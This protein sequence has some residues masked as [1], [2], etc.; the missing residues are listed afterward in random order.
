MLIKFVRIKNL[1]AVKNETVQLDPYTCFVG[2]N[3]VGKSTVLCALNIFFRET[4]NSSTNLS[5]LDAEDFHLRNTDV[6]IEIT[7]TFGNLSPDETETFKDYVRQDVLIVT[8]KAVFDP[9]AGHAVVRQFGSRMAMPQFA[10]Y[11]ERAKGGAKAQELKEIFAK[12]SADFPDMEKLGASME[13]M[14]ASLN[15]YEAGKPELCQPLPSEDQFYGVGQVGK[16]RPYVQ[17]IY[18]PAVKDAADEQ[19]EAGNTALGR[20]LARTVRAKV[21]FSEKLQAIRA[22]AEKQYKALMEAEQGILDD[23]SKALQERLAE[24]SNPD[25][26]A[27]LSWQQDPKKTVS[28]PEPMAKLTAGDGQFEG[29]IARFGHGMQ[30]SY[31]IALLQGLASLDDANQPLLVLGCEEPELYQHPPQARHLSAVLQKL[32]ESNTQVILTTHSPLFVDGGGFESV[33]LV[34][35]NPVTGEAKVRQMTLQQLSE[36][37]AAAAKE[38]PKQINATLVK[39]HQALQP[40]LSEMFFTSKLI[41]VEG[42]EDEAYITAWLRLTN[43]WDDFRRG[44]CH[45]VPCSGKSEIA[46]PL[47]IAL[48]LSV[49]VFAI[50]DADGDKLSHSDPN[51]ANSRRTLHEKDNLKILRLVGGPEDAFPMATVWGQRFVVWPKDMAATVKEEVGAVQWDKLGTA[52][53]RSFDNEADLQKNTLHIAERLFTA[54]EAKIAVPTLDKLCEAIL[55]FG[56]VPTR[57]ENAPPMANQDAP[58]TMEK[59]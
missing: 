35:K 42:L 5:H 34:Q 52:A 24:W 19:A 36:R 49:P 27:K 12:L 43:R 30:R 41:L 37:L 40:A 16:L 54:Q 46:R 8:A 20:L 45:I 39:L 23:V 6:P 2:A 7:V 47:A 33:R 4:E 58:V 25:A 11:F 53:S 1:R 28:V 17:W 44:G 10:T 50:F 21:N 3:G 48:G 9:A 56:G 13:Q 38:D 59:A 32:A 15:A 14:A 22:E 29:N 26:T 51:T 18:I 57:T 55:A 31:L